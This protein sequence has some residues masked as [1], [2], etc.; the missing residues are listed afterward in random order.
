MIRDNSLQ[1]Q[2]GNNE[3]SGGK[4]HKRLGYQITQ[5]CHYITI[6]ILFL[7]LHLS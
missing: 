1:G 3:S 2:F 7:D 5:A 4:R 6:F